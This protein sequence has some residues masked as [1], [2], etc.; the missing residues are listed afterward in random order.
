[1]AHQKL[2][3]QNASATDSRLQ[4]EFDTIVGGSGPER[5]QLLFVQGRSGAVS[6]VWARAIGNG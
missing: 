4:F 3:I 5:V 6:K 1:M 2:L